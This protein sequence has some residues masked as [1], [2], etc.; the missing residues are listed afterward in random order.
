MKKI[1]LDDIRAWMNAQLAETQDVEERDEIVAR[2]KWEAFSLGALDTYA[3]IA[4]EDED[5]FWKRAKDEA[6]WRG[7]RC[8]YEVGFLPKFDGTWESMWTIA[9]HDTL[10]DA[11]DAGEYQADVWADDFEALKDKEYDQ[12][13]IKHDTWAKG[14]RLTCD[15]DGDARLYKVDEDT[16]EETLMDT[17]SIAGSPDG[18]EAV[19]FSRGDG[20]GTPSCEANKAGVFDYDDDDCPWA[21]IVAATYWKKR[22]ASDERGW[23][24]NWWERI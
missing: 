20:E 18:E 6:D 11:Y 17:G 21:T 19:F 22:F 9:E 15:T 24:A 5:T 12:Y 7:F 10:E 4:V 2:A 3:R 16:D 14:W 1:T 13:R 8:D 23:G